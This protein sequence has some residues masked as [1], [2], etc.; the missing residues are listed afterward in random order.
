M[1][2]QLPVEASLGAR[3][4]DRAYRL[5]FTLA[6]LEA[7]AVKKIADLLPGGWHVESN[8]A[9]PRGAQYDAVIFEGDK[10]RYV[11]ELKMITVVNNFTR[12]GRDAIDRASDGAQE[13]AA[14]PLVIIVLPETFSFPE[15][16]VAKDR[17]LDLA[18]ARGVRMMVETLTDFIAMSPIELQRG[19][20]LGA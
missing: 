18:R 7:V 11:L 13:L 15:R 6:G 5:Q 12:R 20:G 9:G 17:L 19:L 14:V 10:P 1:E 3:S 2:V 16:S 4:E 8:L